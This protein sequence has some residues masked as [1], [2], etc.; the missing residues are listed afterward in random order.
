[1]IT[2]QEWMHVF[3]PNACPFKEVPNNETALSLDGTEQEHPC[4]T[5]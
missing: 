2:Y 1:V 3:Q 4:C 5:I